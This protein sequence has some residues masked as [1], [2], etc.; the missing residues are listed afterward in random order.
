MSSLL[1]LPPAEITN[2]AGGGVNPANLLTP[3]PRE[4]WVAP[5]DA[6][7]SVSISLSEPTA[8]DALFLGFA[9]LSVSA[10]ARV[11]VGGSEIASGSFALPRYSKKRPAHA[12]LLLD[13]PVTASVFDVEIDVS[14]ADRPLTLGVA[15]VGAAFRPN[16][17][18]EWGSGRKPIDTGVRTQLQGGGFGI[19]PG[20]VKSSWQ[21]TLGDLDDDEIEQLFS[22]VM[23]RGETGPVLVAENPDTTPGL[24]ERLHYG[25]FD[26][27][28]AYERRD[29]GLTSWGLKIEDWL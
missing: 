9:Q 1:I 6:T 22:L 25:T 21:W 19:D 23:D 17:N 12:L 3:D 14:A 24:C 4:V 10:P 20:V 5:A 18:Y 27:I 2:A 28:E 11:L 7:V 15:M 16:W 29:V 8:V 13:E 26:Q